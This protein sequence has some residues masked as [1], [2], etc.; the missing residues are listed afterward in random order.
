[1]AEVVFTSFDGIVNTVPVGDG[2]SVMH[3]ATRNDVPGIVGECGGSLSCA[4]CHVFVD[5][6]DLARL[7]EMRPDEDEMLDGAAED[8]TECSRLSCQLHLPADFGT[9]HVTTPEFQD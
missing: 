5:K 4:T 3:A 8:R 9:L 7:P 6:E 1:M 2:E